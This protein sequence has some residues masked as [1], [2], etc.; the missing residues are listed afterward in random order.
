M[1]RFRLSD[2]ELRLFKA[3]EHGA[4]PLGTLRV[5]SGR[6][7]VVPYRSVLGGI[8]FRIVE[9]EWS[10]SS[11]GIRFDD[12]LIAATFQEVTFGR[13]FET[14]YRPL[15]TDHWR[16]GGT[17]FAP[18]AFDAVGGYLVIGLGELPTRHVERAATAP[19][20]TDTPPGSR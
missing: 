19:M 3:D 12:A 16:V 9:N 5:K 15:A 17:I 11:S 4:T 8:S 13:I 14:T 10:V 18:L 6:I 7:S 1:I 2:I 20:R